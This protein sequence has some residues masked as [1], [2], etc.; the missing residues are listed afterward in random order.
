M[1]TK[2]KKLNAKTNELRKVLE[3]AFKQEEIEYDSIHP[4]YN[5]RNDK[6]DAENLFITCYVVK[7]KPYDIHIDNR[8]ELEKWVIDIVL[9]NPELENE[10]NEILENNGFKPERYNGECNGEFDGHRKLLEL[11]K[12][13]SYNDIKE[14]NL[15]LLKLF[16]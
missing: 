15:K 9:M 1:E 12:D 8:L 14:I 16:Q 5:S 3:N 2:K 4:S 10:I 6:N 13:I 7:K 11:N